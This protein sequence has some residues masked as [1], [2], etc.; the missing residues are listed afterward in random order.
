MCSCGRNCCHIG[1]LRVVHAVTEIYSTSFIGFT[2]SCAHPPLV[3]MACPAVL[4]EPP[5]WKVFASE[6]LADISLTFEF[7]HVERDLQFEGKQIWCNIV[8]DLLHPS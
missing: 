5:L 1:I 4:K 7:E 8:I 6:S 2:F 3:I